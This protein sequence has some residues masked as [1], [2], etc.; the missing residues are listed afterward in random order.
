MLRLRGSQRTPPFAPPKGMPNTAVLRVICAA[1]AVTSSAST[2]WWKRIPPLPGPRT[3]LWC[4]RQPV[5]TSREPSSMRTGTDTSRTRSGWRSR[6]C[7]PGSTPA[8]DAA[9]SMR[10]RTADQALE[11]TVRVCQAVR[12]GQA[13]E[14]LALPARTGDHQDVALL[15]H[16]VGGGVGE[17]L[18]AR[19]HAHDGDAV[20]GTELQLGERASQRLGRSMC[21]HHGAG[22][23]DVE[24]IA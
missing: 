11:D 23:G 15:Q 13:G 21:L 19:L 8:I 6:A 20:V 5:K 7:T 17:A 12:S 14:G 9:S 1:R 22:R 2:S 10:S 16:R 18:V 24:P 3:V 4:T